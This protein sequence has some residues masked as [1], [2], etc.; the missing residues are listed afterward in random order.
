M[1]SVKVLCYPIFM[2]RKDDFCTLRQNIKLLL[3]LLLV[4]LNVSRMFAVFYLFN[5][6]T[7]KLLYFNGIVFQKTKSRVTQGTFFSPLLLHYLY[8]ISL[9]KFFNDFRYLY[10]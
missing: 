5:L 8:L 6:N 9:P 4:V 1:V 3:L 7:T 10:L 2:C